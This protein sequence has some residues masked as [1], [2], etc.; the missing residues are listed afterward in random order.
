M[1]WWI[2]ELIVT[3][4]LV[5][6]LLVL[7]PLIKRFG[8]SYAAD[9]FR[10]NPRT[11]KSYLVLMDVA[12]YLIFAAFILFTVSFERDSGWAQQVNAEQLEA[13]T[14]RV[15]GMLLLMGILH[16]LNVISL[17]IIGRLLGL[18]RTL[19]SDTP[20]PKAA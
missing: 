19:E 1:D 9:I 10:A 8:K 18:G 13:S 2:L 20:K 12:Y 7:G 11:G 3:G 14:L 4:V 16:G 17:P 5:V 6:I 15:G